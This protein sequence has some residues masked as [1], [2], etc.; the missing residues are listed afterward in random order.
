LPR[1]VELAHS[2]LAVFIGSDVLICVGI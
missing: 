1:S 2:K